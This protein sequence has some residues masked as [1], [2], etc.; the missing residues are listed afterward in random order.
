[1]DTRRRFSHAATAIGL[2]VAGAVGVTAAPAQ[3]D[4]AVTAGIAP[5]GVETVAADAPTRIRSGA[6]GNKAA[7]E[8]TA[9]DARPRS[10]RDPETYRRAKAAAVWGPA[11]TGAQRVPAPQDIGIAAAATAF[12][13]M[14]Q[15][16]GGTSPPDTIV[17]RSTSRSIEAV[18]RS[19]RMFNNDGT[20]LATRTLVD[21]FGED[22]AEGNLFD[23]K[24]YFDR[25]AQNARYYV[26]ALQV[27]GRDD[28]DTSN[29]ISRFHLAIS[30]SSE[31]TSL[32]NGWCDYEFDARLSP[33][34]ANAAW[35]D[36]PGLGV[37]AD[38]LVFTAN[39][40][41]FTDRSY[42]FATV[43]V[44]NK[45]VASNN[46]GSCPSVTKR[47]FVPATAIGD[48]TVQTLQP[49]QH[50][51]SPSTFPGNVNPA[52]LMSV[53]SGTATAYHVWRIANAGST[54]P[55]LSRITLNGRQYGDP[56]DSPQPGSNVPVDTGETRILQVA[57]IGNSLHGVT[58]TVCN[59]TAGTP[60][61]SC[62]LTPR[63]TVGQGADG[64]V[65]ASFAENTFAGVADGTFAAYPSIA[66]NNNGQAATAWL[67]SS[68]ATALR[69]RALFK[70][71]G[72]AWTSVSDFAI[73]NC[74][75]PQAAGRPNARAGDYNGAQTEPNGSAFYLAGE[76]AVMIG[77][78]CQWLTR[79]AR[80]TP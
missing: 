71:Q 44:I 8:T 5:A 65:T 51:T 75:L 47:F 16:T 4:P 54:T 42:T 34:T 6:A 35:A 36:F 40:F 80:V 60:N 52:Y 53:N 69:S 77:G 45:I 7:T 76:T 62:T 12:N 55:V 21:F 29:D 30:R 48:G 66:V 2:V 15:V 61:E 32:V 74:A 9:D 49:A 63:I 33:G 57:G 31:P 14:D 26:V 13:G 3:A 17:A 25:N 67:V 10:V 20:P 18:N 68:S 50:Y 19:V 37:G 79:I 22:V 56:P 43:H 38:S 78:S 46:A 41:R 23:P 72:A 11:P 59:F 58:A 70:N 27:F 73:G 24:I 28:A 39:Q 1:M 64:R